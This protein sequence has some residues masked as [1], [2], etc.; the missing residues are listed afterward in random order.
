MG[1]GGGQERAAQIY[2]LFTTEHGIQRWPLLKPQPGAGDVNVKLYRR[3]GGARMVL[4]LWTQTSEGAQAWP[5]IEV[6]AASA[7][8]WLRQIAPNPNSSS[9]QSANMPYLY[10]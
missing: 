9:D 10:D 6:D 1:D 2:R 8:E 7:T 4:T 5:M 3:K